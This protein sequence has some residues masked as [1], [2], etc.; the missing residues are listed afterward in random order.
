MKKMTKG[1]AVLT[2]HE[3]AKLRDKLGIAPEWLN[4]KPYRAQMRRGA[5]ERR[6]LSIVR[7]ESRPPNLSESQELFRLCTYNKA[8]E[9]YETVAWAVRSIATGVYWVYSDQKG[10]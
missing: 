1:T 9:V 5:I 7:A 3:V 2:T 8:K 10:W 4:G 6:R